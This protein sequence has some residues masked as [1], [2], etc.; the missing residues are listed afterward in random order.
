MQFGSSYSVARPMLMTLSMAK[1]CDDQMHFVRHV[2]DR[3]Y[4]DKRR[5]ETLIFA[6]CAIA[7]PRRRRIWRPNP[8]SSLRV[9]WMSFD[10]ADR[11]V[12]R[13][14]KGRFLREIA[15]VNTRANNEIRFTAF[16]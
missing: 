11:K 16:L 12:R 8:P 7:S 15:Q 2:A 9:L 13:V 3:N 10:R 4:G 14:H 6:G 5:A 1:E